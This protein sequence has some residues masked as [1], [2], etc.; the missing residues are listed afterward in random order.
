MLSPQ[1]QLIHFSLWRVRL[2]FVA[3]HL[4]KKLCMSFLFQ[5]L[6]LQS[7]RY[8]LYT[9]ELDKLRL[10]PGYVSV[11]AFFIG[12]SSHAYDSWRHRVLEMVDEC[13]VFFF[14][15]SVFFQVKLPNVAASDSR[16]SES[17]GTWGLFISFRRKNDAR[18]LASIVG[19]EWCHGSDTKCL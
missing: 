6:L 3:Q 10:S 12:H 4:P 9:L 16:G 5:I 8:L 15:L 1:L 18:R 17:T 11:A 2:I 13:L 14:L 7:R 19:R